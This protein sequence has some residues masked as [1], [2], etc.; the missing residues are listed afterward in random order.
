MNEPVRRYALGGSFTTTQRTLLDKVMA[1][2]PIPAIAA[3]RSI[4]PL[5]ELVDVRG[6][7]SPTAERLSGL[8]VVV[9]ETVAPGWL[10]V[11][12]R[13]GATLQRIRIA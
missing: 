6:Y 5:L 8:P 11:R 7:P 2:A 4:E 1:A 9:D 10:E 12:D 13:A 3:V